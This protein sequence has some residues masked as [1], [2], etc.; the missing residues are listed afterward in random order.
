MGPVN[1]LGVG[2]PSEVWR[3]KDLADTGLSHEAFEAVVTDEQALRSELTRLAR[4]EL[5][6][7]YI[8]LSGGE[9]L[10]GGLGGPWGF[11]EHVA[12]MRP[13]SIRF[14]D[15]LPVTL[16]G[17]IDRTRLIRGWSENITP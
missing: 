9:Y 13:R 15:R 14:V 8:E 17:K 3:L 2:G 10:H 16:H 5:R 11:I 7:I 12:Y 4:L 6:V 1:A